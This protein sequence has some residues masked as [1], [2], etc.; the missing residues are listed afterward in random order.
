MGVALL[1][2]EP[3]TALSTAWP[4]SVWLIRRGWKQAM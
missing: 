4:V 2:I 3:N 1:S